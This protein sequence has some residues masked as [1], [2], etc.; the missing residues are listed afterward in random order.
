MKNLATVSLAA[1]LLALSACTAEVVAS[2]PVDVLYVRPPAPGPDF[3]W[4]S[5]D[6]MWTGN[7]YRWHEGHWDKRIEGRKWREGGWEAKGTGWKWRK[8]HWQ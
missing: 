6:W 5:G 8:G 3:I 1:I 2:R 4:V 7:T